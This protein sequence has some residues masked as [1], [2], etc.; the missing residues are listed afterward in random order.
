MIR[1]LLAILATTLATSASAAWQRV[2]SSDESTLYVDLSTLRRSGSAVTV[3]SMF[4]YAKPQ[5]DE[6]VFFR[7]IK[8]HQ[9]F[10]CESRTRQQLAGLRYTGSMGA[11]K[12]VYA[13]YDPQATRPVVPGSV[14][15]DVFSRVCSP[16][17]LEPALVAPAA[18][19]PASLLMDRMV[20]LVVAGTE[21]LAS[22]QQRRYLAEKC[23]KYPGGRQGAQAWERTRA[24]V[25]G[26]LSPEFLSLALQQV[27]SS[28][29][30]LQAEVDAAVGT[31]PS[32]FKCG[33]AAGNF[34][35]SLARVRK[36]WDESLF[37]FLRTR[38]AETQSSQG[39]R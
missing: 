8:S 5:T 29:A 25:T 26:N 14:T 28:K 10:D 19:V 24:E 31:E 12:S 11:G 22:A 18:S 37:A 23:A 36:R 39:N 21:Y 32:A 17:S 35:A 16:P 6:G 33:F 13:N 7:S 30:A 2:G 38:E 4:D 9:R 15:E 1:S 34:D 3:W 27:A 20:T